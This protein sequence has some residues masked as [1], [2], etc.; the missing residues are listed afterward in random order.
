MRKIESLDNV[1]RRSNALNKY[2]KIKKGS[3]YYFDPDKIYNTDKGDW[4]VPVY[5]LKEFDFIYIGDFKL[6]YFKEVR[7]FNIK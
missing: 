6:S 4:Y 5:E 7:M 3:F 1:T 2:V